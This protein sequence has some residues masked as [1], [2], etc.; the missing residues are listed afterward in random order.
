MFGGEGLLGIGLKVGGL[1]YFYCFCVECVVLVD[2]ISVGG[3][4]MLL[5]LDEGGI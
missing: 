2:M 4:V 5:L 1:C 3:N